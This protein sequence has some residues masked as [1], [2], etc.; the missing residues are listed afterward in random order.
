[1]KNDPIGATPGKPTT[2]KAPDGSCN[3][4]SGLAKCRKELGLPAIKVE[5][6][7]PGPVEALLIVVKQTEIT[8][9]ARLTGDNNNSD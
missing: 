5:S 3:M 2:C 1:M 6:S 8:E 4:C 7:A 9:H